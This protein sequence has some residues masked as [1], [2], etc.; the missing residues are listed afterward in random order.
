MTNDSIPVFVLASN[1][2]HKLRELRQMLNLSD[3]KLLSAK[4]FPNVPEPIEDASTFE[5]NALIKARALCKAT[6]HW[7]IADDS[8]LCVNALNGEPGVLSARYAGVHGRDNDN[9]ELLLKNLTNIEDR[10]AY[11]VSAIALVSPTGEE[12]TFLGYCHGVILH[13][14]RGNNGF[15]YDP[16]FLPNGYQLTYA[17]LFGEEKNKFSHRANA[18]ILLKQKM[19]E[20][21]PSYNKKA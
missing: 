4:D 2:A 9:N 7:A 12:Y 8:G 1:N 20:I 10:S 11:F 6:G 19:E 17:E 21:F 13:A 14:P 16:L 15:G 3:D 5:G 18:V